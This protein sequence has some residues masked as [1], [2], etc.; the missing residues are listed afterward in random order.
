MGGKLNWD[1][2]RGRQLVARTYGSPDG[3]GARV[4]PSWVYGERE[5]R[6]ARIPALFGLTPQ[7][8]QAMQ[9]HAAELARAGRHIREARKLARLNHLKKARA[10]A[11]QAW[12]LVRPIVGAQRGR[13]K[14]FN[15]AVAAQLLAPF[16]RL[17]ACGVDVGL[18]EK[19]RP[20]AREGSGR[21]ARASAK[22]SRAA[23][24]CVVCRLELSA[25]ERAGRRDR[26]EHCA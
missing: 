19:D 23:P 8:A 7:Q 25:V 6:P 15:R 18:A 20:P 9:P 4:D 17:A 14:K 22:L 3:E 16:Q 21:A 11:Q 12:K 10:E 24:A 1:A 2:E 26:H 13:N 5:R